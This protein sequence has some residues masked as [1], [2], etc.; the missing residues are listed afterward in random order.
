MN[1][2]LIALS[3]ALLLAMPL[4]SMA[5]TDFSPPNEISLNVGQLVNRILGVVWIIFLAVA[6]ILFIFGGIQFLTAQG[7]PQKLTQAKNFVI[8]GVVGVMVA[9]LA[10][11][12]TLI[13]RNTIGA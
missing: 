1:K 4:M 5:I 10:F 7:E 9:V 12:I 11:S 8:W 2:K 6:I 13:V 3:S